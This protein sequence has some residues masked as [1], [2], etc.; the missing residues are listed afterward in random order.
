MLKGLIATTLLVF[1]LTG[2][3]GDKPETSEPSTEPKTQSTGEPLPTLPTTCLIV[4]DSD[5]NKA[6]GLKYYPEIFNSQ[7]TYKDDELGALQITLE[8]V[9]LDDA[10]PTFK[11]FRSGFV[12]DLDKPK[13]AEFEDVGEESFAAVGPLVGN[14]QLQLRGGA[15]IEDKRISL[16]LTQSKGMSAKDLRVIGKTVLALAVIKTVALDM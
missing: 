16:E 1:A 7:C 2:C 15:R 11:E 10:G 9:R 4:E 14:D 8:V 6:L 5:I 12:H 3:G 13:T